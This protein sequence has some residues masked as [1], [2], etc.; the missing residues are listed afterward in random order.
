MYWSDRAD[1]TASSHK[2]DERLL[3]VVDLWCNFDRFSRSERRTVPLLPLAP[4]AMPDEA[5]S[6]W[7]ARIAARYDVSAEVLVRH[8][9]PGE[10]D[11]PGMIRRVDHVVVPAL[12]AALAEATATPACSFAGQRL[13]ALT[14][15]QPAAWPR[16]NPAWCPVCAAHDVAAR[17]E[18][19]SRA[20]W[21][22]GGLLLCPRHQCLLISACPRCFRWTGYHP[23]NGRLRIWCWACGS[24]ADSALA[25]DRIPFWPYGT[26]QQNR[27]CVTVSFSSETRP[28]L[29]RVQTDLMAMLAGARPRGPWTRSL[30]WPVIFTVLRAL[31]FVMLGP[32]WADAFRAAP[33]RATET[34]P[35]TLPADWSPGWLPPKIAAPALLAAVTFLAAESGTRLR[36]ITWNPQL[37]LAGESESI[38]AETLLWHLD[39]FDAGLIQDL[40]AVPLIRP[41]ALLIAALRADRRGLGAAREAARRRQ[42]VGGALRRAR[43]H[44]QKRLRETTAAHAARAQRALANRPS[45]RFAFSRVFDTDTTT[46]RV[47]PHSREQLEVAVAVYIVIGWREQDGDRLG[48]A[49][50]TPGL[51]QNR[52]IRLWLFRHRH[53]AAQTLITVLADAVAVAQ[54]Q[55]RGIVL[56]ELPKPAA[57]APPVR[58]AVRTLPEQRSRSGR[59]R[60]GTLDG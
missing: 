16:S 31:T 20:M 39:A 54:A 53:L 48:N 24:G 4:P 55:D 17:G 44:A 45:E 11:V 13:A 50:W 41:F 15:D 60:G 28:L 34:G 21:G 12:E 3:H 56:P 33:V 49:D 19:Y 52:Y 59:P 26:P 43:Q 30:K 7:R 47:E 23:M 42:G 58:L 51:L 18:V 37:L 10:A 1:T 57:D 29:L 14:A 27:R 5:P 32:L 25:P 8:L 6:S 38:T 36:G 46:T 40:F 2:N 35:W 22:F 9:L